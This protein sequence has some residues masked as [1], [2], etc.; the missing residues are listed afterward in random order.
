MARDTRYLPPQTPVRI[1]LAD[2]PPPRL[3]RLTTWIMR[4]YSASA[5]FTRCNPKFKIMPQIVNF[6]RIQGVSLEPPVVVERILVL[7]QNEI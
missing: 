7:S 1:F 4:C 6:G 3:Q 5:A 2:P